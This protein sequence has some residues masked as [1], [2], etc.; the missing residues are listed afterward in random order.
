MEDRNTIP[1]ACF[2]AEQ[3]NPVIGEMLDIAC[4]YIELGAS[5][6]SSG[7]GVFTDVLQTCNRAILFPPGTLYP[8]HYQ[9]KHLRH[10]DHCAN[11]WT[12]SIHHWHGSWLSPDR[13]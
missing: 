7:P 8:Y 4:A 12:H 10:V 2:G 3:G 1:D 5:P 9:Q 6:W 13:G 11:P